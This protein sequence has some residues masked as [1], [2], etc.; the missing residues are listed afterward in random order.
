[1]QAD[2][3]TLNEISRYSTGTQTQTEIVWFTWPVP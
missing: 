1:M 2:K 3:R